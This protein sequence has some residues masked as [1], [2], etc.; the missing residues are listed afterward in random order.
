MVNAIVEQNQLIVDEDRVRTTIENMSS[1]YE[2][3]Q[4][5]INYYYSNE[6]QLNQI[7]NLVLEDQVIDTI[8]AGAKVTDLAM[9]YD[10]AIKPTP[11]PLPAESEAE[12]ATESAAEATGETEDDNQKS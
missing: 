4:E 11:A 9:E 6:Q 3:P 2:E 7:R 8:L 12:S 1:S 5:I 10:A